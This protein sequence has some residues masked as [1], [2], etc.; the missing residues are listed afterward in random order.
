MSSILEE[1]AAYKREQVK[2]SKAGNP[3]SGVLK[4]ARAYTPRD[5]TGTLETR[6]AN[7]KTAVI[8]E[9]KKA[10]PSRGVI[11]EDFDPVSIAKSYASGGASC[12]SVL[13]DEQYFQGRDAYLSDIRKAASLPILRKDFMLDPYQIIEARALGADAIL[14]ILAMV[15]DALAAELTAA[16]REQGLSI[17]PE[18]HNRRELERALKL[19]THLIGINNR[20]LHSFE[21]TLQTTLNLLHHVPADKIVIS[22][23]GIHTSEDIH[24]MSE[25]GVH[26]FL[27]GE[28][29]MR[30]PDPGKA[31]ASLLAG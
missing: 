3:E 8:A 23:S 20:N 7:G 29:L 28:S 25:A 6:I 15:D 22:E 31:L 9:V 21:I 26:G 5:F 16:A 18:V 2:K 19:G 30:Q 13:T 17:L 12:L 10:S 4:R 27:I 11:R 14:I 1:I 24:R